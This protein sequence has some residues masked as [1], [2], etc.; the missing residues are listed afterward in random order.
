MN[1]LVNLHI[2]FTPCL[3]VAVEHFQHDSRNRLVRVQKGDEVN[4]QAY[5]SFGRLADN[6]RLGEYQYK[7]NNRYVMD[8]LVLNAAGASY[9]R[10]HPKQAAA[11]NMDRKAV[12]V[13]EFGFG[14]ADFSYGAAMQRTHAWYGNE[15]EA[16][17]DRR[18]AKHYSSIF[19]AEIKVDQDSG[20]TTL[21]FFAGG[22]AYTA[23]VAIIND[24]EHYLHRDHLGSILSISDASGKVIEE[25]H[26]GAW[27]KVEAFTIN[28]KSADFSDSLLTRGFTGHEHFEG[29]TLIHMPARLNRRV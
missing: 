11:Y 15:E 17:K 10:E 29:I 2:Y 13:H 27:G 16:L 14:R 25:R 1:V 24:Q 21:V 26:F 20:K 5:E 4:I 3:K 6:P 23:P 28:G 22:D 19:P 12:S 9:Y 7:S 8:S 18:F